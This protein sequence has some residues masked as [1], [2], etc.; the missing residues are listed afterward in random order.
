MSPELEKKL[1]N[2]FP[3]YTGEL[4]RYGFPGDGW[5]QLLWDLSEDVEECLD[6]DPIEDFEVVQV[7]EKFGTLR[8]YVS[9]G[10]DD[11][12][13]CIRRAEARSAKTCEECGEPGK[14]RPGGWILTLCDRCHEEREEERRQSWEEYKELQSKDPT[15]T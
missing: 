9:H 8:Y 7:K 11:I 3:F 12:Y 15:K 2:R 6:R 10:R 1:T 14:T 5:F 13:A 4:I